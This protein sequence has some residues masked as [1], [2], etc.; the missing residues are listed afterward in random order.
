MAKAALLIFETL[1]TPIPSSAF[2]RKRPNPIALNSTQ[3]CDHLVSPN[4]RT[5][6]RIE[7]Q[8]QRFDL[9]LPPKPRKH[10]TEP[11]LVH[12]L[13][14]YGVAS[15]HLFQDIPRQAD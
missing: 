5:Q 14:P 10:I 15:Y 6:R 3:K 7:D 12:Q 4:A 13:V 2:E 9:R 8:T 1:I 11:R